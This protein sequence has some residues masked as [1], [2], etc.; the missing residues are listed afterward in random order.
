M[1]HCTCSRKS[2]STIWHQAMD[3][4][5][6]YAPCSNHELHHAKNV[7][8]DCHLPAKTSTPEYALG[9]HD[10]FPPC[11]ISRPLTAPSSDCLGSGLGSGSAVVGRRMGNQVVAWAF[12]SAWSGNSCLPRCPCCPCSYPSCSGTAEACYSDCHSRT[13]VDRRPGLGICHVFGHGLAP[14]AALGRLGWRIVDHVDRLD[15]WECAWTLL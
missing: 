13:L 1:L 14:L 5:N 2:I 7:Q 11:N 3:R 12:R 8:R 4:C 6:P 15:R 10:S 9:Y